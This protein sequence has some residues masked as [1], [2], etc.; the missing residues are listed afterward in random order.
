MYGLISTI[1]VIPFPPLPQTRRAPPPPPPPPTTTTTTTTTRTPPQGFSFYGHPKGPV[2]VSCIC[3]NTFLLVVGVIVALVV[4]VVAVAA[5]AAVVML[6]YQA[7]STVYMVVVRWG[8]V[9]HG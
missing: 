8:V 5:L 7:P 6:T 1:C 3:I 4:S 2:I 9:V